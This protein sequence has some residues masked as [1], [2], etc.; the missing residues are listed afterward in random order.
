M[1]IGFQIIFWTAI[2]IILHSYIFFPIILNFISKK[3]QEPKLKYSRKDNLPTVSIIMAVYNEQ[4]IIENKINSVFNSNYPLDKIEFL[5]GSDNSSDKTN[6]IIIE[7]KKK[8]KNLIFFNFKQRQGKIKILNNLSEK[9][10]N[11]IIIS[12]DAKAIFLNNTIFHLIEFFKD[13]DIA[14]VGGVLINQNKTVDKGIALQEDIFMSREMK[15]KYNEGIIWKK[16]IGVYGALFAVRPDFF[17]E[18][19][20]NLLVDDF[21]LTLKVYEKNGFV[22]INKRAKA[23]E[24][25]PVKLIEEF[26]RKVRIATGNFQNLKNFS[27]LLLKPFKPLGFAFISHKVIRWTAPFIFIFAFI[28]LIFLIDFLFYKLILISIFVF[29]II[30]LMDF[31][32]KSFNVNIKIFRLITHFISM[33]FALIIGFFRA[34]KGVKKSI[35]NPSKRTKC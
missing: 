18:V 28:F 13:P 11:N 33:N 17:V 9:C 22:L 3:K 8:Y 30:P 1:I 19:P 20:E 23:T 35:W 24:N 32:L 7:L 15:I 16:V 14:M 6:D 26:K 29:F 31:I 34:I 5:I 2:L 21:Y 10:N 25:L 12:T 4:E 27:Y